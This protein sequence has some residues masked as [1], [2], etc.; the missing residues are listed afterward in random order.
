MIKRGIE[1]ADGGKAEKQVP[2]SQRGIVQFSGAAAAKAEQAPS[3]PFVNRITELAA[4]APDTKLNQ[5]FTPE[6]VT[7]LVKRY[8]AIGEIVGSEAAGQLT[9]GDIGRMVRTGASGN[10]A[11]DPI[12]RIKAMAADKPDAPLTDVFD[13]GQLAEFAKKVPAIAQITDLHGTTV[14]DAA[15]IFKTFEAAHAQSTLD[16]RDVERIGGRLVPG[17]TFTVDSKN[18]PVSLSADAINGL[19]RKTLL[20][21]SGLTVEAKR[22]R[23]QEQ[24][25]IADDMMRKQLATIEMTGKDHTSYN[26]QALKT[27]LAKNP[28][29]LA[30]FQ[31][32]TEIART[33]FKATDNAVNLPNDVLDDRV[34]ALDDSVLS[35][36]GDVDPDTQ[37]AFARASKRVE[38]LKKLREH[39]PARAV[40]GSTE[41]KAALANI[42]NGEPKNKAQLFQLADATMKAQARLGMPQVPITK[43][44]AQAIMDDIINAPESKKMAVAYATAQKIRDTYGSISEQ[45]MASAAKLARG[46]NDDDRRKLTSQLRRVDRESMNQVDGAVSG[47][48]IKRGDQLPKSNPFDAFGSPQ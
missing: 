7:N 20:E 34:R 16:K 37:A 1:F 30:N 26:E 5:A 21:M 46:D 3:S 22:V 39:D 8:P 15:R 40:Q 9:I 4:S 25:S 10:P 29:A 44:T 42:P 48:T 11:D 35:A 45:V 12:A 47:K 2:V 38:A 24:K 32:K 33:V 13:A 17:Q 28:K 23:D 18:G 19:D 36:A 41:V 43:S 6:E 31:H 14:G 27:A